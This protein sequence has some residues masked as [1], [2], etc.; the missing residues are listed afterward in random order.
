MKKGDLVINRMDG[1]QGWCHPLDR[2]QTPGIV[3]EVVFDDP[4]AQ[5]ED[6]AYFTRPT[7]RVLWPGSG[8][9]THP[10]DDLMPLSD[11]MQEVQEIRVQQDM[12]VAEAEYLVD[13][14]Y[15]SD[16]DL[17]DPAL[18]SIHPHPEDGAWI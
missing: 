1:G 8:V 16:I 7:V 11:H 9:V 13:A 2:G 18:H 5:G 10:L 3:L 12:E 15:F 4:Y 14:G 6:T 17:D